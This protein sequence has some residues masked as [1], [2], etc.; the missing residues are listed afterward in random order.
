MGPDLCQVEGVE[1]PVFSL[2]KGH[3]LNIHGPSR[4]VSVRDRIIQISDRIIG[5]LL[6]HFVRLV[7]VK[8]L[9]A[10]VSLVVE[11]AV[12]G[13]VVLVHHF[14]SVRPIPIHESV[15]IRGSTIRE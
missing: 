14:E 7:S 13:L 4:E 8:A 5:I 12:D 6:G 10:L 9:D 2:F 3:H 11:L 15:A 1:F